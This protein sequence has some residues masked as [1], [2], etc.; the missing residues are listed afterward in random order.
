MEEF[1]KVAAVKDIEPGS[2][3]LIRVREIA[4]VMFNAG[5]A[6]YAVEDRCTGDGSSLA[7]TRLTGT[8]IKCP[9]DNA[10]FYLPSGECLNQRALKPLSTL[11]VRVEDEEIEIELSDATGIADSPF[12]RNIR[13]LPYWMENDRA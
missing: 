12:W 8:M 9:S 7:E 4:V 3:K 5:G 11:R 2:A 13:S 1:I 10:A 6:F